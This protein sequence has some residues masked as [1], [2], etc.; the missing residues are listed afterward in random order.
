[1]AHPYNYEKSLLIQN[2]KK[3]KKINYNH[4]RSPRK[5][6][7]SLNIHTLLFSL[8]ITRVL[9]IS[10]LFKFMAIISEKDEEGLFLVFPIPFF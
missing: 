6:Q 8:I 9:S 5:S 10:S 1:M 2:L 7:T 3:R 4:K